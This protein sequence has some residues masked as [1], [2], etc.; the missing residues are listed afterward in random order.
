MSVVSPPELDAADVT[1]LLVAEPPRPAV[2]AVI[3]TT[4]G[5]YAWWARPKHLVDAIPPIPSVH[6]LG[7]DGWALLYVGIAPK[8]PSRT[9]ADRTVAARISKDHR[10]GNIGGSTFRQSLAALLRE[11]LGLIAKPGHDRARLVD[12]KQLSA[13]IDTR[14]ALT[15]ASTVR[16]WDTEDDVIRELRAPL[17]LRPG[18]HPFRFLVE[19]ARS[20]LRRDCGL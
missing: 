8:R 11:H 10:T 12:E 17:N 2:E 14:C 19:E 13:W 15:I 9:G 7:A 6:S 18:Y 1:A 5:F 16:P 4:P 20:A 3:P